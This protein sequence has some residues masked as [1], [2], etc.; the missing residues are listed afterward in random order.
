MKNLLKL[1]LVI[2]GI[3]LFTCED[4]KLPTEDEQNNNNSH[5]SYASE[6]VGEYNGTASVEAV[7]PEY[8]DDECPAKLKVYKDGSELVFFLNH[9]PNGN[10][11]GCYGEI[12]WEDVNSPSS[13][14]F[15]DDNTD[16]VPN[17]FKTI[18]IINLSGND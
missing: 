9:K 18:D 12:N 4:L 1:I 14:N 7:D 17:F 15:E 3:A 5:S 10:N 13:L 8:S 16:D 11:F 6:W 2:L